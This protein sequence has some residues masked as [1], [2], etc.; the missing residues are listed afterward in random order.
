V[1]W[2]FSYVVTTLSELELLED[3]HLEIS[4]FDHGDSAWCV[5]QR[6]R[7]ITAI[8]QGIP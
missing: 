2:N 8:Q 1:S 6:F 4:A 5:Q 3:N 7:E